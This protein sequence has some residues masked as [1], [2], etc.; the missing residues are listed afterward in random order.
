MSNDTAEPPNN[1][2]IVSIDQITKAIMSSAA[3]AALDALFINCCETIPARHALEEMGHTKPSTPMHID[4]TTALG[5]VTNST[6]SK[7]LKSMDMK[8]HWLCCQVAQGK[9][10]HYWRPGTTN[11]GDYVRIYHAAIHHRATRSTFLTP[12]FKLDLI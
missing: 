6:V 8:F 2:T 4:H 7:R 5:V 10:R 1:G 9:F 11:L 3:E 12:K